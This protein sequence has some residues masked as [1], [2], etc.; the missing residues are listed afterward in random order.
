MPAYIFQTLQG[1][2][3]TLLRRAI[4][5]RLANTDSSSYD[6]TDAIDICF[7]GWF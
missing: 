1:K 2:V 5:F 7:Q 4:K 3:C 6:C